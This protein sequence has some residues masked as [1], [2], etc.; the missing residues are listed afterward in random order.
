MMNELKIW[1]EGGALIYFKTKK[2]TAKE[3]FSEFED[4][5]ERVQINIDN[6]RPTELILQDKDF[7]EFD[8]IRY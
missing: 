7:I 8:K 3:A 1:C 5:C 4:I 2:N 6:L